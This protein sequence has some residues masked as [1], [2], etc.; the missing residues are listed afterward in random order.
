MTIS[1]RV[2]CLGVGQSTLDEFASIGQSRRPI[3]T[4]LNIIYFLLREGSVD[5]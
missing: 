3:K 1:V 5:H 2:L 4:Y